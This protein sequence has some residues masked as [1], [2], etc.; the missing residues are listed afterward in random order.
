MSQENLVHVAVGVVINA[1]AEVLV[2]LRLASSHQG[3]LWEF[4]GGKVEQGESVQSALSREFE[5]ELG[6]TVLSAFPFLRIR[7]HYPD[8]SVLLDVWTISE[9]SGIP[10]GKEGQEVAWKPLN[11]LQSD[12]FPEANERIIRSLALPDRIA[13]TPEASSFEE[14]RQIIKHLFNQHPGLIYF[15]QNAQDAKTYLEWFEWA[16]AECK[17]KNITLM[18]SGEAKNIEEGPLTEVGAYHVGLEQLL[19]LKSRPV[20]KQRLF[21][22]S[23]YDLAQLKHAEAID[24]DFAFLSPVCATATHSKKPALGWGKFQDLATQ[25]NIPVYALGGVDL[26]DVDTSR[27]H[28]GFG[29]AGVSTFTKS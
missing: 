14:L 29:I 6:I 23:C 13:I 10:V 11:S 7:H 20:S 8:K 25:V 12:D 17:V 4:P 1:H 19:S 27:M 24:V 2:S 18:Y 5:E 28:K 22:A 16:Q 3:G 21:S 26:A 9:Y 15:R